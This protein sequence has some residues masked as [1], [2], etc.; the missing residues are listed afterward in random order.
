MCRS[1]REGDINQKGIPTDLSSASHST[2]HC[3]GTSITRTRPNTALKTC[4]NS[5]LDV[6][7]TANFASGIDPAEL[8]DQEHETIFP[9][10]DDDEMTA[11]PSGVRKLATQSSNSS[12]SETTNNSDQNATTTVQVE[13]DTEMRANFKQYCEEHCSLF[14]PL[15]KE[16]VSGIH[17]MDV[18]RRKAPLNAYQDV[19]E[20]HLKQSGKLRPH[21]T[22]GHA[23]GLGYQSRNTLMKEMLKRYNLSNML[24]KEKKIR[25]PSSKAVVSIPVRDAKD[26]I[27]SLLTDPRFEDE[28]YIFLMTIH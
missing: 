25:L 10:P 22:L 16:Q 14:L 11:M 1:P 12:D 15:T 26:C 18:L 28:D 7:E 5:Q 21:E 13:P 4:P 20:W 6:P 17:L 9:P 2:R 24:P 19:M 8:P 23:Q 27:V 3:G